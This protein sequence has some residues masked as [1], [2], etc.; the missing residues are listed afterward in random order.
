[1]SLV[2]SI[3]K[4]A[5]S[6]GMMCVVEGVEHFDQVIALRSVGLDI[7]QGRSFRHRFRPRTARSCSRGRFPIR[8]V[9][10]NHR[11]PMSAR[12]L[13]SRLNDETSQSVDFEGP[14]RGTRSD[15]R[16]RWCGPSRH[17]EHEGR[18]PLRMQPQ[19]NGR[20]SGVALV[21]IDFR[22][23]RSDT[24]GLLLSARRRNG[25]SFRRRY[26]SRSFIPL[27]VHSSSLSSA[28]SPREVKWKQSVFGQISGGAR[29]A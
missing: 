12:R 18:A 5:G 22:E 7:G 9:R 25:R 27:P 4:F 6:M 28:T 2:E 15:A 24:A 26:R 11:R 16:R 17:G 23:G 10:L 8:S 19:N 20:N 29:I 21:S 1:M 13:G 3:S 14:G